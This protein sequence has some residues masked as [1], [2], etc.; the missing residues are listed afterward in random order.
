MGWFDGRSTTRSNR[1]SSPNLYY[2]RRKA[3]PSRSK[4]GYST[5]HSRH[6]AP[7][8]FSLGR[9]GGRSSPAT[10]MFS[11]FSSSSRRARPREGFVQRMIHSIKRLLR[12]IYRY[13]RRH[14]IK[15]LL[16]VIVP[17]LTSGV[18]PKLLGMVGLRLPPGVMHALGGSAANPGHGGIGGG[19]GGMGGMGGKGLSELVS[20][21]KMFA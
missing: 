21:A 4:S 14:P 3:S 15:V 10:S 9:S 16:L 17:L 20:L 13:M 5:H 1:S 19:L 12:D 7:S 11:A 6:S 8:I 18:L 2:V